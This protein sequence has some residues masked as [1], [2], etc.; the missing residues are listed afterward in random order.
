MKSL[1]VEGVGKR[2]WLQSR[3]KRKRDAKA[4]KAIAGTWRVGLRN[5][6]RSKADRSDK[7]KELW[8]LKDV[9]FSVDPGTILG[10]IGPNGAGKSTLLKILGRVTHPTVGRATGRGRVA[11]LLELGAGFNAAYS[12]IDNILMLASMYGIPRPEAEERIPEIIEFAGLEDFADQAIKYY[13]SGMYVRLAFSASM[14]MH[15]KILLADE[16]LAVGDMNF[17]ERCLERV[18]EGARQDGLTVLFVSH[19]MQAITRICDRVLWLG[20]GEIQGMGDPEQIVNEYQRASL[21]R[22]ELSAKRG[23]HINR[24]G[25]IT[26]A[27]LVST[28]GNE[29]AGVPTASEAIVRIEFQIQD[30]VPGM[31]ARTALEVLNKGKLA[32]TAMDGEER[33]IES[34]GVY[35]SSARIPAGLLAETLYSIS[36]SVTLIHSNKESPMIAHRAITFMAY[37]EDPAYQQRSHRKNA[38]KYGIGVV[39]PELDWAF[40]SKPE[41][42]S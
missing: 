41:L 21:S 8:A 39:A 1:V 38:S 14:N 28:D 10:V 31:R 29:L 13:S 2:Y 7:K 24:Y 15:P 27:R 22:L 37:S 36:P 12:A 32:F 34:P 42:T 16:V 17:Q 20:S 40:A 26:G 25:R 9:T 4:Q 30:P 19:D 6:L 3:P 11:S 18:R 23:P 5:K 35:E 33:P